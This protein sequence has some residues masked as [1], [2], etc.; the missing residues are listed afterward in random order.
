MRLHVD[1]CETCRQALVAA[2]P[3]LL[4]ME[5]RSRALPESFWTGFQERLLSRIPAPGFDW[6]FLV[7][8]PRLAFVTAPLLMLLVL[9]VSLFVVRP[10]P[11]GPGHGAGENALPMPHAPATGPSRAGRSA[12][13]RA[14]PGGAGRSDL[15]LSRGTDPPALEEVGSPGARVYRFTVE[16]GETETPIYLVFDESIDL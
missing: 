13:E 10:W 16:G 3:A 11:Y 4:F 2:E 9:G 6:R 7:H 12:P 8:Y 1:S 15:P 5:L 14:A